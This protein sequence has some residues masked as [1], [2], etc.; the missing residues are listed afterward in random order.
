MPYVVALGASAPLT[1]LQRT[2][3]EASAAWAALPVEGGSLRAAFPEADE[4]V[5]LVPRAAAPRPTAVEVLPS[6]DAL[7]S[8]RHT[9][10]TPLRRAVERVARRF[11]DVRLLVQAAGETTPSTRR[12]TTTLASFLR[13]G[14][15]IQDGV[16]LTIVQ[17]SQPSPRRASA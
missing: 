3:Q 15:V 11:G 1:R 4:V 5:A 14:R 13:S 10:T 9:V 2:L 6:A 17:Q 16:M 12:Q 8:H 7:I